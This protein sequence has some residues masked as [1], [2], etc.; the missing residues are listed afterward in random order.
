MENWWKKSFKKINEN[1]RFDYHRH[2]FFI[3]SDLINTNALYSFSTVSLFIV[4]IYNI[5]EYETEWITHIV[6]INLF[7]CS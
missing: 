5:G 1:W 4:S 2:Y 3:R 7:D 6:F